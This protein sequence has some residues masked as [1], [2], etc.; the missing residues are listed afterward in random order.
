MSI[1]YYIKNM[2]WGYFIVAGIFYSVWGV[3]REFK[4]LILMFFAVSAVLYPFS[5]FLIEKNA[6]RI[7]GQDYWNKGLFSDG[8]PKT[9]MMLFYYVFCLFLAIPLGMICI[10]QERKNSR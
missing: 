5:K 9:K 3:D 2:F 4:L 10:A 1:K 7:K 8:V 6:I